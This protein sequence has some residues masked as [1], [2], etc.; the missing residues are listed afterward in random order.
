MTASAL[1]MLGVHIDHNTMNRLFSTS[2]G[3]DTQ[4]SCPQCTFDN[5]SESNECLMC[6]A[7]KPVCFVMFIYA[8]NFSIF[9]EFN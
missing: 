6:Y 1:A 4:W 9:Y 3:I 7:P 5:K 2:F 8:F